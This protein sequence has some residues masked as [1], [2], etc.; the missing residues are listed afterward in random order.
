M[1]YNIKEL[2]M[3]RGV[4]RLMQL[5]VMLTHND[6]TVKNAKAVF[7]KCI[8]SKAQFW[9]FKEEG[10]PVDEMKELFSLM[11]SLG[12][13]TFLEVV[14]YTEEQCQEGAEMALTCG[15]DVLMGTLFFDSVNEFCRNHNIRYMPFVGKVHSRPS[16]LEGEIEDIINEAKSYKDKGVFGFDLLG[17]RYTGDKKE[18]IKRFVKEID[19]PVCVAGSIGSFDKL[20]FLAD[21]DPWAFTIGGAFFEDKFGG[22]FSAQVDKVYDYLSKDGENV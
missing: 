9:G 13:T 8:N 7:E 6:H 11:K 2:L 4:K 17:Y 5:I 12:K 14:A 22:E 19:M 15:C 18:L 10:L 20:D 21:V 1:W 16:V 3:K